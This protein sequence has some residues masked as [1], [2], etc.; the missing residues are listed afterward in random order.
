MDIIIRFRVHRVALTGDTE[1]AFLMILVTPQ[2]R[3]VLR[4]LWV[5]DVLKDIPNI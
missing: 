2:D 3:D 1:K 5:D 4:F